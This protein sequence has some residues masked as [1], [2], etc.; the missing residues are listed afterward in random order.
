MIAG[1]FYHRF[2]VPAKGIIQ[3]M[4]NVKGAS[5]LKGDLMSGPAGL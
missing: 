3:S 5:P 2:I 4:L 1:F